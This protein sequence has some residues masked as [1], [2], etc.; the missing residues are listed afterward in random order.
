MT[1]DPSGILSRVPELEALAEDPRV[2][3]AIERGD[4]HRLYRILFWANLFGRMRAHREIIQLLLARRRLF[5]TPI[6]SAPSLYTVNGIGSTAYGHDDHDSN[7]STFVLTQYLTFFFMPLFPVRQYL[8]R[9]ADGGHRRAWTFIGKVPFG[10]FTFFWNRLVALLV[11]AGVAFGGFTAWHSSRFHEVHVINGTGVPV[12]VAIGGQRAELGPEDHKTMTVNVGRQQVEVKGPKGSVIE[13]TEIDVPSGSS[14]MALNVLGA[15]PLFNN[16]VRYGPQG[17]PDQPIEPRVDAAC[18]RTVVR[19]DFIDYAFVE[20]PKTISV[21]ENSPGASRSYV[22]VAPG[23]LQSCLNFLAGK[24]QPGP[25][26][27]LARR[28]AEATGFAVPAMTTMIADF[29]GETEGLGASLA[30]VE[31]ARAAHPEDLQLQRA[32]QD[33]ATAAGKRDELI[34]LFRKL[35]DEAPND[36]DRSYLLARLLPP[37]AAQPMLAGLVQR[38]PEHVWIRRA[39]AYNEFQVRHF[40]TALESWR[41]LRKLAPDDWGETLHTVARALVAAGQ[42]REALREI[43]AAFAPDRPDAPAMAELYARVAHAVGGDGEHLF[44]KVGSAGLAGEVPWRRA[45]AGLPVEEAVAT[46]M[47]SNLRESM[48]IVRAARSDPGEALALAGRASVPALRTLDHETWVLIY[49]EAA[50]RRDEQ[51]MRALAPANTVK[52][53]LA[54]AIRDYIAGGRLGPVLEDAPF[55]CRAAVEFV[56]S[57]VTTVAAGER[58]RL[59]AVARKDD[60]L[61]GSVT[62]AIDGWNTRR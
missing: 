53:G 3:R 56:R 57:R 37:I 34:N 29:L 59:V 62:R 30:F 12:R 41:V 1:A 61:R 44:G 18:G 26:A 11:V 13:A 40:D 50:R 46:G 55:E 42:G 7:D 58:T 17:A 43:E 20:P 24:D 52:D 60:L 33:L 32:F 8:V 51:A 38:F 22:N 35:H 9:Q 39:H 4:L 28:V 27:A 23:G 47:P 5:L 6:R 25:A 21:P 48:A 49:A 31:R 54:R 2:R 36:P 19:Y 14:V 15:A 10:P 45:L 16:E